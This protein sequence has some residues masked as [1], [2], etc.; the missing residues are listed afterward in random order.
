MD[1]APSP[2]GAGRRP[3]AALGASRPA[4]RRRRRR[5]PWLVGVGTW[6]GTRPPDRPDGAGATR[7]AG[8][9]PRVSRVENAAEVAW[10]ANGVLHLP[11]VDVTLPAR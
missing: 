6:L 2:D 11:H 5:R 4:A 10:W 1:P 8:G 9:V 7:G 3:G